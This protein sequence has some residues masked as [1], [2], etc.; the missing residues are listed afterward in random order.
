MVLSTISLTALR[1]QNFSILALQGTQILCERLHELGLR[2]GLEL[3]FWGRAPF[4]GPLLY[5]FR[6]T[7]LALRE[8]EASCIQVS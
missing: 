8:E 1:G 4:H 3:E 5:R 7:M 6:N 2:P